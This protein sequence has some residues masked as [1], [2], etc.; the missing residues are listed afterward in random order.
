MVTAQA[1]AG[2]W[3][4]EWPTCLKNCA[5]GLGVDL[6][7]NGRGR[8]AMSGQAG[9][10]SR[11]HG[12]TTR[13]GVHRCAGGLGKTRPIT[14]RWVRVTHVRVR[15]SGSARVGWCCLLGKR[16]YKKI[17]KIKF[18]S[19]QKSIGNRGNHIGTSE[20]YENFLRIVW[21]IWHHFYVKHFD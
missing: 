19:T 9:R 3:V 16:I 12:P 21:H 10:E 11:W 4:L 15:L 2:G 1:H 17:S 13:M 18:Y 5:L 7:A 6:A 20:K 14:D 8:V